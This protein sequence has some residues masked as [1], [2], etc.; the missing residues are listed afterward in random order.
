MAETY[1]KM[2]PV[3]RLADLASENPLLAEYAMYGGD[4]VDFRSA[5][6]RLR[7]LPSVRLHVHY[8]SGT[9]ADL[10]FLTDVRAQALKSPDHAQVFL[11]FGH[12]PGRNLDPQDK[13]LPASRE[14][15]ARVQTAAAAIR[16]VP[17]VAARV[18]VAYFS[19]FPGLHMG[20]LD[21]AIHSR[22]AIHDQTS[23]KNA[24]LGRRFAKCL[25]ELV[26]EID[27]LRQS[28]KVGC[29]HVHI[30]F[31]KQDQLPSGSASQP[32]QRPYLFQNVI[33]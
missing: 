11:Y 25:P 33:T 2:D 12:A 23:L 15:L 24:V 9:D 18:R 32:A 29:V 6:Q 7:Q 30:Y 17:N 1:E 16:N 14:Y 28:A 10:D 27:A 22:V 26:K 21:P 19:C 5:L 8:L 4:A 3:R 20:Y 31:G 13:E